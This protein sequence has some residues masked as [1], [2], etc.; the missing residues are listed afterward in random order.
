[1]P[2]IL[3]I[4]LAACAIAF[5]VTH[6]KNKTSIKP[7]ALPGEPNTEKP[8]LPIAILPSG[9]PVPVPAPPSKIILTTHMDTLYHVASASLGKV[10]KLDRSVPN[11]FGCASSLSGILVAAGVPG[12]PKLGIAG[13]NALND[14]LASNP[15]FQ[16][17]NQ[18]APGDIVMSPS[19]ASPGANQLAHGHCGVMAEHGICSNDSDTG[20]WLEKWTLPK[21]QDYYGTYG[22][23]P[24]LYYRWLTK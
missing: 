17:V 20:E 14:W 10:M 21:W 4:V 1:M 7:E 22:R 23:L 9:K 19:P 8:V 13:T 3:A 2:Y 5:A 24:V 15:A 18:P 12:L 16:R 11:L 6:P